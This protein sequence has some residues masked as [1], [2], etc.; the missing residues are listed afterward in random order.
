MPLARRSGLV[1]GREVG[2]KKARG[3][4]KTTK[5]RGN[6]KTAKRASIQKTDVAKKRPVNI[7]EAREK[8]ARLVSVS[9]PQIA[10][11]VIKQAKA[12]QLASVKYMFEM[13]GLY[14]AKEEAVPEGTEDSPAYRLLKRMAS[15]S[16]PVIC[17]DDRGAALTSDAVQSAREATRGVGDDAGSKDLP[18]GTAEREPA[19]AGHTVE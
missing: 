19:S 1:E 5:A 12:G 10:I 2:G 15:P 7:V 3:N 14:P 11:K 8:V 4:S 17:E 9:A 16:E 13:V 6:S 18:A